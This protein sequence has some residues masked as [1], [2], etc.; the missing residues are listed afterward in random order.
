[1]RS[2]RGRA[3]VSSRR[4]SVLPLLVVM[5]AGCSEPET[6]PPRPWGAGL[7]LAALSAADQLALGERSARQRGCTG[8][9]DPGDGTLAG[10]PQPLPGTTIYPS[11]LTPDVQTG[12]GA[13]SDD[14]IAR[15]IRAGLDDQGAPL[16]DYMPRFA[17]LDVGEL[18]ALI[19]YLRSLPPVRR[20]VP[21]S[22]C[23]GVDPSAE[24]A[25]AGAPDLAG[26]PIVRTTECSVRINEVQTS[27]FLFGSAQFVELYNPCARDLDLDG[28]RLVYRSSRGSADVRLLPLDGVRLLPGDFYVAGSGLYFGPADDSLRGRLAVHGGGLAVRDR[29]DVVLD[30][31]GWGDADNAYVEGHAAP[32]PD[33]GHSISRR[34]DGHGSLDD[35]I[36]FDVTDPSPEEPNL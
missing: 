18:G 26:A 33:A 20:A 6:G 29:G 3:V 9:H 34:P 30:S 12:I 24:P 4:S 17:S 11:N 21:A 32:A 23:G 13:W 14:Q 2:R 35:S 16:C 10:R 5:G 27:D 15:A 1:M 22:S 28:A 19:A 25:D 8:C 7:D 36:D 31:M